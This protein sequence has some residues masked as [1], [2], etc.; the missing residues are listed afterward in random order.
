VDK[1]RL[2]AVNYQGP[3]AK[4]SLAFG[5]PFNVPDAKVLLDTPLAAVRPVTDQIPASCRDW[6]TVGRW[7]SVANA[8][9]GLTWVTLDAPLVQF[10]DP[11]AG[12]RDREPHANAFEKGPHRVYSWVMNNRW[13]TNYRAYQDGLVEFRYVL[14][15]FQKSDPAEATRFATGF[16]QPLLVTNAAE[17]LPS[18]CTLPQ[19]DSDEVVVT[20]AK[21]SD[22]GRALIVRLFGASGKEQKVSLHWPG[23]HPA[24]LFLSNTSEE[25]MS[26]INDRLTV[27]GYGVVTLRAE[28]N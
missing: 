10:D 11:M 1:E 28:F 15:P 5:F 7:A 25:P 14:R 22:D 21:P 24:R 8:G 27:A 6:F 17:K 12:L 9:A 18:N 23:R 16:D 19:L 4:E 26:K 2:E 13:G 3:E 20:A